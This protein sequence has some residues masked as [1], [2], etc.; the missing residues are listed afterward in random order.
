MK[1]I[2][3]VKKRRRKFEVIINNKFKGN[4][5]SY[6]PIKTAKKVTNDLIGNKKYIMF[7]LQEKLKNGKIYGPYIGYI[8]DG[9]TFAK[10]YKMKGGVIG[11]VY[12]QKSPAQEW[13]EKKE[14]A[15]AKAAAKEVVNAEAEAKADAKAEAEAKAKAKA[16]AKAEAKA[17]AEAEA[18]A[19][20]EAEELVDAKKLSNSNAKAY[21]KALK[22]SNLAAQVALNSGKT[23]KEEENAA[24]KANSTAKEAVTK[25]NAAAQAVLNAEQ[26]AIAKKTANKKR[27]LKELE[28][29]KRLSNSNAEVYKKAS[30]N[31]NLVA[32][33][34]LNSGKKANANVAAQ[35]VV[36][37]EQQFAYS[38]TVK[39]RE[40]N[41]IAA[42]PQQSINQ[43]RLREKYFQPQIN[44]FNVF[45]KLPLIE[46]NPS[47]LPLPSHQISLLPRSNSP[48]KYES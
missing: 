6:T 41:N 43:K 38:T 16:E 35:V 2:N 8:K 9:K 27:I 28:N 15:E 48:I 32:K 4:Y 36:N 1:D 25:A 33:I 44:S 19:K 18:K 12:T 22:N 21:E 7:H 47:F 26:T 14:A 17:K 24:E 10:L 11:K 23:A 37:P 20:A 39:S 3:K 31:A 34:G 45:K 13:K 46:Y 5:S 30:A 29:A 42:K 40:V